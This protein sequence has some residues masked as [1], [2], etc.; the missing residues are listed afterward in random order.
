MNGA[1]DDWCPRREETKIWISRAC[2]VDHGRI[3]GTQ[4]I[5]GLLCMV[6]RPAK[7]IGRRSRK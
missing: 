6:L 5:Y 7:I 1:E 2:S 4:D 3:I